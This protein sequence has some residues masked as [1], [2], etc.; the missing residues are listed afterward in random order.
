MGSKIQLRS[1]LTSELEEDEWSGSRS[2]LFAPGK[3]LAVLTVFQTQETHN[4]Y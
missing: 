1:F 2:R 4:L 3:T